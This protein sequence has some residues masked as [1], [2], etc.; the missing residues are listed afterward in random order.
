[1]SSNSSSSSEEEWEDVE[2]LPVGESHM[3]V[4][5]IVIG[6]L[7]LPATVYRREFKGG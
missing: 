7:S 4:R 1:M 6:L 5:F 2:C 3:S